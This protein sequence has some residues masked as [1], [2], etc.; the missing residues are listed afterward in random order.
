MSWSFSSLISSFRFCRPISWWPFCAE[1][2]P[3]HPTQWIMTSA[4]VGNYINRLAPLHER[5]HA[6]VLGGHIKVNSRK[7]WSFVQHGSSCCPCLS[8][9]RWS[10]EGLWSSRW[11]RQILGPDSRWHLRKFTIWNFINQG[12]PTGIHA[13]PFFELDV[14]PELNGPIDQIF[15]RSKIQWIFGDLNISDDTDSCFVEFPMG[16]IDSQN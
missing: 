7:K 12:A 4:V 10:S 3:A 1:P 2:L 9:F 15:E 13:L 8:A 16:M 14:E 6:A 5:I 11:T